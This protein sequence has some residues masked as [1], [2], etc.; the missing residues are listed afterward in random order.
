MHIVN[1]TGFKSFARGNA[2]MPEKLNLLVEKAK[3]LGCEVL[4]N[5]PMSAH[6]TFKIGG[7]CK[8]MIV[9]NSA[10]SCGKLVKTASEN[11]V[12]FTVVGNGS[13]L[14]CDDKGY[15][16]AISAALQMVEEQL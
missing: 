9:P 3:E 12:R 1:L 13:N 7:P 16:S 11:G 4:E 14:L 8:A 10:E 5:E 15:D 6:T 2:L